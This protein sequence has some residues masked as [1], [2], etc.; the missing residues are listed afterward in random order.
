MC[1]SIALS[2]IA[3][4]GIEYEGRYIKSLIAYL[5]CLANNSR[6]SVCRF[7]PWL[8]MQS[9]GIYPGRDGLAL[10]EYGLCKR[11]RRP[12]KRSVCGIDKEVE[13]TSWAFCLG[14]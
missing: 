12:A 13:L 1:L 3:T 14:G 2:V 7:H 6:L 4:V 11:K 9:L 5:L 10:R 8:T